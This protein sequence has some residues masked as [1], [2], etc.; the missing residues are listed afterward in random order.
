MC[1][2]RYKEEVF[3]YDC[4]DEPESMLSLPRQDVLLNFKLSCFNALADCIA[5]SI[6]KDYEFYIV[7]WHF[8][9]SG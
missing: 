1:K 5:C 6:M 7:L 8:S 9:G 2:V 3:N 4:V